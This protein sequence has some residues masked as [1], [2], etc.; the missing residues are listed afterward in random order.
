MVAEKANIREQLAWQN[1]KQILGSMLLLIPILAL[2]L[3]F[4]I[5]QLFL[6][7]R[8]MTEM[9]Q[10]G[11]EPMPE[12]RNGNQISDNRLQVLTD[13]NFIQEMPSE[14]QPFLY[15]MQHQIQQ[16]LDSMA[17]NHRFVANASHQ[18]RTPMTAVLLQAEQLQTI[19]PTD[20]RYPTKIEE[21][22]HSI[23]RSTHLM[24]QL[25][26]LAKTDQANQTNRNSLGAV[27]PF[28]PS[29]VVETV[30][31]DCYPLAQQ[32]HID[33][34]VTEL[35]DLKDVAKGL[36]L[37]EL[38]FKLIVQNLVENAIKYTP[39]G[40]QVEISLTSTNQKICL[41][42]S[43]TGIGIADS[44]LAK[45]TEPFYRSD[46][47]YD[48]AQFANTEGFG[49]GLSIVKNLVSQSR[50]ILTFQNRSANTL[51]DNQPS[52]GLTVVVAWQV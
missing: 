13:P 22:L 30:L 28:L 38:G 27:S 36:P 18:L 33:L 10:H 25:L 31:I 44:E 19:A 2:V 34:A 23:K 21:L 32:K 4:I 42:V 47:L 16:L 50:G 49:L 48:N 14:I 43:D 46:S 8:T 52:S 6:P 9:L 39:D 29:E 17:M 24:N 41:Q 35:A 11:T 15:V 26:L 45:I 40:G 20:A 37:N 5:N 1:A 3:L 12:G 7:L 51:V